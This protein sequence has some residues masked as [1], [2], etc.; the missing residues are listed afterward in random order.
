MSGETLE[1]ALHVAVDLINGLIFNTRRLRYLPL[2]LVHVRW[3][4]IFKKAFGEGQRCFL[5]EMEAH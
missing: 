2:I 3:S 4:L 5:V 1:D